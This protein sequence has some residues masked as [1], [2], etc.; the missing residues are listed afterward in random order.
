MPT[1]KVGCGVWHG[2]D[3]RCG[4]RHRVDVVAVTNVV[5]MGCRVW[6]VV[7]VRARVWTDIARIRIGGAAIIAAVP[8]RPAVDNRRAVRAVDGIVVRCGMGHGVDVVAVADVVGMGGCVRYLDNMPTVVTAIVARVVSAVMVVAVV[9][10]PTAIRAEAK[11][12]VS[13]RGRQ[14]QAGDCTKNSDHSKNHSR[15]YF[16]PPAKKK[17]RRDKR[18]RHPDGACA[19]AT[20]F[21]VL[22]G[23]RRRNLMSII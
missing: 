11:L 1:V 7:D 2:V 3:M 14:K 9:I 22:L 16:S 6:H 4:V 23:Y 21:A 13:I 17:I 15:H 19:C 12:G 5:N 20:P 8:I 10:V 18:Q